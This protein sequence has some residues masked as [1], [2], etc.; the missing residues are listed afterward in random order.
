M[1]CLLVCLFV[2]FCLFLVFADRRDHVIPFFVHANILPLTFLYCESVSSL[3][4]T[5]SVHSYNTHSSTSAN[6]Y[7]EITRPQMYRRSFAQFGVKLWNRIPR[8][9]RNLPKKVFKREIRRLLLDI[10][11]DENDYIET[12]I[13]TQKLGQAKLSL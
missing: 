3:K 4:K 13:V 1:V 7:V 12:P 2:Q 5:S 6:F 11:A 9:L 10:L 8:G